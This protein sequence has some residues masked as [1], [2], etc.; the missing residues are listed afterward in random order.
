MFNSLNEI[1]FIAVMG[2]ATNRLYLFQDIW[3]GLVLLVNYFKWVQT[4]Y[5]NLETMLHHESRRCQRHL[6]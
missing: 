5:R 2:K 6:G 4:L 3:L 1:A